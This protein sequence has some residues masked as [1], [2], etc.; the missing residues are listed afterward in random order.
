MKREDAAVLL[1]VNVGKLNSYMRQEPAMPSIFFLL[2]LEDYTGIPARRLFYEKLEKK[3]FPAKPIRRKKYSPPK[4]EKS[5]LNEPKS[6]YNKP[7]GNQNNQQLEEILNA[8]ASLR[9]RMKEVEEKNRK[10][11]EE[12]AQLKKKKS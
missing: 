2:K 9:M 12:L 1:D 3:D 10:L 11:E 8:I 6:E 7:E 5:I 4:T